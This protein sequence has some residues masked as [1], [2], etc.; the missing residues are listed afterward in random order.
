M[1]NYIII[2]TALISLTSC[3]K[4]DALI[5]AENVTPV[6]P[7]DTTT[8]VIPVIDTIATYYF[9]VELPYYNVNLINLVPYRKNILIADYN[10]QIGYV[11]Y[12]KDIPSNTDYTVI[13]KFTDGVTHVSG[14]TN[15]HP[16]GTTINLN[17][18]NV[19]NG[20]QNIPIFYSLSTIKTII[21]H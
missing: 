12:Y 7:V 15:G 2:L 9:N 8:P 10:V 5:Q 14:N 3:S 1:K 4:T 17:H 11:F 19:C 16:F 21:T 6:T 13:F 18:V 20:P